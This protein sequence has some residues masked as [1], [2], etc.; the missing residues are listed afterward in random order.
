[1]KRSQRIESVL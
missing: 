1:M